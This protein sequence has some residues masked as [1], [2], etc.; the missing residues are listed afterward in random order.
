VGDAAL[1]TAAPFESAIS[2]VADHIGDGISG[3][4]QGPQLRAE[5]EALKR[6]LGLAVRR[7]IILQDQAREN[8]Y[9]RNMLG[10]HEKNNR[11]DLLTAR[12]IGNDPNNLCECIII[13]RGRRDGLR[14]RM[15]VLD[16]N[17][18]YVGFISELTG[19]AAKVLLMLSPSSSVAAMDLTTRAEGLVE[20]QFTGRP[21]LLYVRTRSTLRVNDLVVTSGQ[22]NLF[23]RLLLLGQIVSVH[24]SDVQPFQ[25]AE[26]QPAANFNDLEEVQIVRNWV[27]SVPT[28][29]LNKP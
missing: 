20:G 13:N 18:Y 11:M 1:S 6:K 29:L 14:T 4:V 25:T 21:Q 27:P 9:L 8:Q 2:A 26:I 16:P 17:G 7:N 12:V 15:T 10:F 19:N 3:M 22:Y 5:N 23:P 28:Q 24:H